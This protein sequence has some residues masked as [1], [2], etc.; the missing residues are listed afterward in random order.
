MI[1]IT[2][3]REEVARPAHPISNDDPAL[4]RA[5]DL[6]VLDD[7]ARARL[8][9]GD[10][11]RIDGE[12]VGRGALEECFVGDSEADTLALTLSGEELRW[13]RNATHH[14]EYQSSPSPHSHQAFQPASADH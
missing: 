3:R 4:R 1:Q 6:E 12:R 7:G 5:L 11:V 8:A 13:K 2:Q 14:S 10:G 9:F